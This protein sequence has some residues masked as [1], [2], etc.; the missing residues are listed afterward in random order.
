ML[1]FNKIMSVFATETN[2]GFGNQLFMLASTI[3]I[4]KKNGY[5]V[6]VRE[7]FECFKRQLPVC[8]SLLPEFRVPWGYSDF[9]CPDNV[10][11]SGYMQSER[12]FSHCESLIRYY[13]ELKKASD[14][15]IPNNAII[16]HVRRGDYEGERHHAVLT[17]EYYEQ[18]ISMFSSGPVLVFSD[19][20][21]KAR[22]MLPDAHII[23]EHYY[24]DFY[25]MT[26]GKRHVIANSSFSWWSAW[27]SGGEV[28]APKR[29]FAG[30]NE[31][32][33]TKDIYC[34]NW[35]VI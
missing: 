4:A 20:P 7:N 25:L 2:T 23:H 22:D 28:V 21:D 31:R 10:A 13:F 12:Y 30:R 11:L 34:E 24:T 1:T 16:V 32:L 6:G 18:G 33:E 5:E 29:W 14:M 17:K 9:K 27:L 8:H 15:L 26:Q 19:E 35:R 3:G